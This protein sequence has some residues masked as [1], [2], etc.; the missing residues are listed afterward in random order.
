M[1]K[2]IPALLLLFVLGFGRLSAQT[3]IKVQTDSLI[4]AVLNSI[5]ADSVGA[6]IQD[7]QNFG[8]RFALADNRKEVAEW[9]R[10]KFNNWGYQAKLDSF[11]LENVE[12]PH[13]SNSFYTTWQYN[14]S[15]TLQGHK[16]SDCYILGAHYD[17]IVYNGDAFAFAPGADDNASGVAA[18]LETARIFKAHQIIPTHNIHFICYAAEELYLHGS[19]FHANTMESQGV[20]VRLMINND[21]IAHTL[22]PQGQWK[23]RIQKY[24]ATEWVEALIY[25]VAQQFTS[26]SVVSDSASIEYSD[27]YPYFL[28]GF[29]AVF[30]Q[31]YDFNHLLHTNNDLTDTL[32]MAYCAEMIKISAAVLLKE[33]L[34]SGI[35]ATHPN[36]HVRFS[37]Y[38]NP[39][40]D[41]IMAAIDT[42]M[43]LASSL[44]IY[45][46]YGSCLFSVMIT[47]SNSPKRIPIDLSGWAAGLYFAVLKTDNGPILHKFIKL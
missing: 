10:D 26:L 28:K 20:N 4:S 18:V 7:M 38:P 43:P 14:V 9:L 17:A 36:N 29:D 34:T 16:S 35:S 24:P 13:S 33:N 2:K 5:H 46:V 41:V 22:S 40:S 21:M 12:W 15:A 19:T 3:D 27:S 23:L 1:A 44:A 39:A 25:D 31:E 47:E 30:L 32:D 6:Y 8:T 11:L 45:D 42:D 37:V